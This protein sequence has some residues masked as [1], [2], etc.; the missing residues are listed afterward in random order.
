LV[1]QAS[2]TTVTE[3]CEDDEDCEYLQGVIEE[4]ESEVDAYAEYFQ[5]L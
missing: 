1:Q 2:I 5:E 4:M 3:V